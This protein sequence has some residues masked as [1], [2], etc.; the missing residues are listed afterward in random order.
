MKTKRDRFIAILLSLCM[1]FSLLPISAFAEEPEDTQKIPLTWNVE[2]LVAVKSEADEGEATLTGYLSVDGFLP[3]D[4]EMIDEAMKEYSNLVIL[5]TN[6]IAG[7]PAGTYPNTTIVYKEKEQGALD[8]FGKKWHTL[9]FEKYEMP[10]DGPKIT[11]VVT[12]IEDEWISLPDGDAEK[13][14]SVNEGVKE[15]PEELKNSELDSPEKIEEALKSEAEKEAEGTK[16][17]NTIVYDVKLMVKSDG[18]WEEATRE[19]FPEDGQLLIEL[20]YPEDIKENPEEYTFTVV[21]MFTTDDFG[22]TPGD[23]EVIKNEDIE[24][25]ETGI[26]FKVTGLSPIAVSYTENETVV[27]EETVVN[28]PQ[29]KNTSLIVG[30]SAV[31][32]LAAGVLTWNYAPIHKVTGTVQDKDRNNL[33]NVV[34]TLSKDGET[35]RETISEESG[36]YTLRAAKGTYILT[37]R[38]IV[39]ETNEAVSVSTEVTLPA[40][41]TKYDIILNW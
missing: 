3:E 22:K 1:M 39:P 26:Q 35:V 38:Y 6:G 4:A 32:A 25:T 28:E 37:A 31:G 11:A 20:P 21:H 41:G 8:E 34:I 14:L 7:M 29:K 23:T 13:K 19:N 15:V 12:K 40:I 16:V 10:D 30:I 18:K 2:H 33:E 9:L 36:V 17:A 27:P 5:E 24:K